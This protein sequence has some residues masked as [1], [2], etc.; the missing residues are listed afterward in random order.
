MECQMLLGPNGLIFARKEADG[1]VHLYWG[2]L[3]FYVYDQNDSVG[4]KLGIALLADQGVTHTTICE[5]FG[6][7]RHMIRKVQAVNKEY[8][9]EGLR[10]HHQGHERTDEATCAFVIAEYIRLN[11]ARGYQEM[12]LD[13]IAEKVKEGIFTSAISRSKLQ[14]LLSA[15]KEATRKRQDEEK[16]AAELKK[17][18]R[19]Q[20]QARRQAKEA[21]AEAEPEQSELELLQER[22]CVDHGG[23]AA[24]IPLLGQLG[25]KNALP[26]EPEHEDKR[27]SIG[28]LAVSYAALNAAQ[29]VEVEQDFKLA[30]S[31]QM[32]GIIGRMR[33]PSLSVFRQ[34][35]PQ[36]VEKMDMP[37]VML[38]S[39]RIA[40]SHFG[41]TS[42]AY[43]DG[44]FMPYHGETRILYGYNT[45]RRLAMPGREYVYVHDEAGVPIFGSLSDGYRKMQHYVE[46]LDSQIR[47][48]YGVG[49]KK[50]LEVFD[51]GGYSK[52]FLVG[53]CDRIKFICWR[54][55]ARKTPDIPQEEWIDAP[56]EQQG[57][58]IEDVQWKDMQAWERPVTMEVEGKKGT[59]REIWIKSGPKVSAVLSN[60]FDRTLAELVAAL[61]G[62]W[63]NQ[64]N[65]F[66]DL[67]NHGIDKI[68]SYM[69]EPYSEEH[70]YDRNLEDRD[71]GI[72]HEIGNPEIRKINMKLKGLRTEKEKLE[73]KI[74]AATKRK[75]E[76]V[77]GL[78]KRLAGLVRRIENRT[79]ERDKLPKNILMMDRIEK[80]GI[81]RLC[82]G[83]KMYFD[84]LKMN[85]IWS[86][87]MLV[88]VAKPFYKDWRDVNKFVL[89]IL[90]S[91]TYV[92]RSGDALDVA[93]PPQTSRNGGLALA[94]ICEFLNKMGPFDLGLSFRTI[95]FRVGTIH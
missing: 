85:A 71:T 16:K 46:S 69:N 51:R 37:K 68:H 29:L 34:R 75:K 92:C 1:K 54:S 82:D 42:I 27:Y 81:L 57:N 62:R 10:N 15:H 70:L 58:T 52:D 87:K 38:D 22:T 33:L 17:E 36:A 20:G 93:F 3:Q 89:S 23:A 90:Q 86:K 77:T 5:L 18:Q 40:V 56:V 12:I 8:G 49:K 35:I 84:W 63:G 24:I 76:E 50:I 59:F 60:D 26:E 43:I 48:I 7:E 65:M 41:T 21:K 39:A 66:K 94:A 88:E 55:D 19:Q 45:Q 73:R 30:A 32:G 13:A 80:D 25:L 11:G 64:E 53:I 78:K 44:H 95:T 83:K 72:Q 47:D 91:R 61:T 79:A 67:K 2:G 74:E 9:I 31:Y 6:V 14:K 28:E 4:K